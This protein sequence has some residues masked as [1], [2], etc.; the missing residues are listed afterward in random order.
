VLKDGPGFH[1][2]VFR[3]IHDRNNQLATE[4]AIQALFE[5][6]GVSPEEFTRAWSSFEVAQKMRVA[7]DLARRYSIASTPSFVVNGKYRT[8]VADAGGYPQL[9]ELI[10]ELVL[11]ESLR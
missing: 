11:R 2:T 5:R 9:L 8:S 7:Q 10:D 3:E 4:R 6:F 1:A